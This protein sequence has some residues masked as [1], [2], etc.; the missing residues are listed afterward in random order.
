MAM[1]KTLG[2]W[3]VH[4]L[5]LE[6]LLAYAVSIVLTPGADG[7]T[8]FRLT[9]VVALLAFGGG[10]VPRA[11][12]EGIPWK[13]IPGGLL[14]ALVYAAATAAIFTWLWPQVA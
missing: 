7:M 2:T 4:I 13:Q 12:W 9:S 5:V 8:V 6:V 3:A 10:T 11:I 1:G 14:D